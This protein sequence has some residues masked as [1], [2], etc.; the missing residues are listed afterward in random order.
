MKEY[1]REEYKL[2]Q[3]TEPMVTMSRK[4]GMYGVLPYPK[5]YVKKVFTITFVANKVTYSDTLDTVEVIKNEYSVLSLQNGGIIRT[6]RKLQD[7]ISFALFIEK[8]PY[9]GGYDYDTLVQYFRM[10]HNDWY[11]KEFGK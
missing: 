2:F 9:E 4:T 11:V 8:E 6:F 1:T 10:K 7:A 3:F 5:K